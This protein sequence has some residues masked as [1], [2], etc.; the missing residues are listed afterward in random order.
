MARALEW[1]QVLQQRIA[2]RRD[3]RRKRRAEA[4]KRGMVSAD[5]GSLRARR[6]KARARGMC[7]ICMCRPA[8]EYRATCG[9]CYKRAVTRAKD[10]RREHVLAHIC[11]R[12]GKAAVPGATLCMPHLL[13]LRSAQKLARAMAVARG[14]CSRCHKERDDESV[15]LGFRYCAGCRQKGAEANRRWREGV[16]SP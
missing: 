2:E 14:N 9:I 6:A 3:T 12:C 10:R 1:K 15:R 13:E 8:R 7:S 16:P 11:A 4:T 5:A